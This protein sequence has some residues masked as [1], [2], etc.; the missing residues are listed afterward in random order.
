MNE[1]TTIYD[2]FG[3][4]ELRLLENG[5]LVTFQGHSAGFLKG[6]GVYN[7]N[8]KHVGW[9]ENGILRD[10]FGNVVGFDENPTDYPSPIL[11]IQFIKPI[12]AIEEV[13]Q[14]RPVTQI[15][16]IKP[17]KTFQ[18]SVFTPINLFLS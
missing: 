13:E 12:P 7:Y 2:R 16:P 14:I 18:W 8:G 3:Y 5:R 9:Y 15:P 4:P 1:V 17:I 10:H 6:D 11:P